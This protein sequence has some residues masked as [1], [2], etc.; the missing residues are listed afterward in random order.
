MNFF[1]TRNA[2]RLHNL[3]VLQELPFQY[4]CIWSQGMPSKPKGISLIENACKA[5]SG[6]K[7]FDG[8]LMGFFPNVFENF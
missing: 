4:W 8:F 7:D 6:E 2:R 5:F 3:T 1:E